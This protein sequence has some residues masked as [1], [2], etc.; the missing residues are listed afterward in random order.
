M[1][2]AG[3]RRETNNGKSIS[4]TKICT[5]FPCTLSDFTGNEKGLANKMAFE[6]LKDRSRRLFLHNQS[7]L[8]LAPVSI[9][10]VAGK[11]THKPKKVCTLGAFSH[12]FFP[13][14]R[15]PHTQ[16]S[17][18]YV[19]MDSAPFPSPLPPIELNMGITRF[20]PA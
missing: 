16:K 6:Y 10:I 5:C 17:A 15:P 3:I 7:A 9:E 12:F 14:D 1:A 13:L 2:W 18:Q 4:K 8:S 20:H 19:C 11:L